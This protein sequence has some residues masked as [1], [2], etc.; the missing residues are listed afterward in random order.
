G[1]KFTFT[2]V[3]RADIS[4]SQGA[5][6]RPLTY[7][8]QLIAA[9]ALPQ[10]MEESQ[11]PSDVVSRARLTLD[12][13]TGNT[14]GS[15]ML[16]GVRL[17]RQHVADFIS[18]RDGVQANI[19]DVFVCS[20]VF[21][22][23]T[24]VMDL[25]KERKNGKR[26]GAMTC[27]PQ[28]MAYFDFFEELGFHKILY[29]LDESNGWAHDISKMQRSLDASLKFCD[30][31]FLLVANPANP[32]GNNHK[33]RIH[34]GRRYNALSSNERNTHFSHEIPLYFKMAT[35]KKK[36]KE[37]LIA[38]LQQ[39]INDDDDD[40][41][42]FLGVLNVNDMAKLQRDDPE[43]RALIDHLEG[44]GSTVAL[45][46]LVKPPKPGVPSYNLY[47]KE[48]NMIIKSLKDRAQLIQDTLNSIEGF[49]CSPVQA[50]MCGYPRVLLPRKAIDK[51]K[52]LGQDPSYF[53][54][55]QLLEK[56]G[57]CVTPG[58]AFGQPPG[59]CHSR[60]TILPPM[61]KVQD[62]LGRIKDFHK[63]FTNQY[64]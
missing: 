49:Y 36:T 46:C 28:Y 54:V 34:H 48:K 10:L 7:V 21:H 58:S 6:Q 18:E 11:L 43:L 15:V 27:M 2:D 59:T 61:A 22:G 1:K 30:P 63:E 56:K 44:R 17:I 8:R 25:L 50:G 45:D 64:K 3:I 57:V 42:G 26:P 47:N 62:M 14:V 53:Y 55:S 13:C 29:H 37:Q 32:T 40:D 35:A 39:Y 52:S 41:V 23:T 9:C 31:R 51:A 12:H 38:T 20:G 5:G 24:L 33:I 19:N 60:V 4:D 16:N